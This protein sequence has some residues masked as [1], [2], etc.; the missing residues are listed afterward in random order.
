[1]TL[2]HMPFG[3]VR[4]LRVPFRRG[5]APGRT[6]SGLPGR[7]LPASRSASAFSVPGRMS[8]RR[9]GN[10][11][12]LCGGA[13]EPG[14]PAPVFPVAGDLGHRP[15]AAV[16]P[17]EFA[18]DLLG[19]AERDAHER[20]VVRNLDVV[21]IFVAQA[22]FEF[23]HV[24]QLACRVAVAFAHGQEQPCRPLAVD[25]EGAYFGVVVLVELAAERQAQQRTQ[26]YVGVYSASS[27]SANSL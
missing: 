5:R 17:V 18:D 21:D 25:R 19:I 9:P 3:R 26:G 7:A 4:V 16:Q 13:C 6:P 14:L 10:P 24:D 15:A 22:A 2:G 20:E 12:F 1:M 27:S 11:R 8:A 23:E